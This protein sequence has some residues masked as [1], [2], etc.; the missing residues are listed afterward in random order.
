[1]SFILL[2]NINAD[3]SEHKQNN[4]T[5]RIS[6]TFPGHTISIGKYWQPEVKCFKRA[7]HFIAI[8]FP[9]LRR[10]KCWR[11]GWQETRQSFHPLNVSE[12]SLPIRQPREC[13]QP[14]PLSSLEINLLSECLFFMENPSSVAV[15]IRACSLE[16]QNHIPY[17]REGTVLQTKP[18]FFFSLFFFPCLPFPL[19]CLLNLRL[20]RSTNRRGNSLGHGGVQ[21]E[22]AG[23]AT[24]QAQHWT[25]V[26][27]CHI[28]LGLCSHICTLRREMPASLTLGEDT[29]KITIIIELSR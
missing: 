17:W 20:Y 27:A 22:T 8:Y 6:L 26:Q 24:G 3:F 23:F 11:I 9:L 13:W 12:I 7:L 1:M 10:F 19:H 29:L 5:S 28:S 4:D 15:P 16:K 14:C 25:P 18:S 21:R 2:V